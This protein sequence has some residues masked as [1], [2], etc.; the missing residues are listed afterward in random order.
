[1]QGTAPIART[2]LDAIYSEMRR[3][4]AVSGLA[5]TRL[6]VRPLNEQPGKAL[7]VKFHI[8]GYGTSRMVFELDGTISDREHLAEDEPWR[9]R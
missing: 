8:L 6:D 7:S 5:V 9:Q 3:L 2:Q 1:M 4:D